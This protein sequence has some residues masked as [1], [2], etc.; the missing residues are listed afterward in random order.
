MGAD[1]TGHDCGKQAPRSEIVV[2]LA[3]ISRI[4][5]GLIWASRT[6]GG[7]PAV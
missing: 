2:D 3:Y 4:S 7:S 1:W 5:L 6:C